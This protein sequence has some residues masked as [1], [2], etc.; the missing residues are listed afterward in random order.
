[1]SEFDKLEDEAVMEAREHPEQVK[2]GEEA[3][4]KKL[5]LD[6]QDNQ[7]GPGSKTPAS[8]RTVAP[9]G[10]AVRSPSA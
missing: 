1:M 8:R 6:S 3:A 9:A 5:E 7:S 4:K 2:K 10:D